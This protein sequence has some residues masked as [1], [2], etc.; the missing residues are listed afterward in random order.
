M[1]V[2]IDHEGVR[3]IHKKDKGT[4]EKP[5]VVLVSLFIEEALKEVHFQGGKYENCV[6]PKCPW[7]IFKKKLVNQ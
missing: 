2:A 6:T 4:A 7:E 1:S 3:K 5:N